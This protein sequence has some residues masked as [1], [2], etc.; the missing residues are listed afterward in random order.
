MKKEVALFFFAGSKGIGLTSHFADISVDLYRKGQQEGCDVYIVSNGKEQN[1]GLWEKVD[2]LIPTDCI[3]KYDETRVG[4]LLCRLEEITAKYPKCIFHLQG[5]SHIRLTKELLKRGNIKGVVTVHS[6]C[7]GNWK[8]PIISFIYSRYISRYISKVIFLSPFACNQFSGSKSL[9]RQGKVV[10]IPFNLPP[11]TAQYEKS[12]DDLVDP[13]NYNIV[14]LANFFKNKGHEKY[15]PAILRFVRE[16]PDARVYFF[17]EGVRR[18]AVMDKIKRAGA[19]QQVFCP[20]RV[21][22]CMVPSILSKSRATLLLSRSENAN[23]A[24]IESL[25]MGIPHIS[26]RVGASEY[27]IQDYVNGI[28]IDDVDG[29]YKALVFLKNSPEQS[30]KMAAVGKEMV[31]AFY[32]YENMLNAYFQLYKSIL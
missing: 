24:A 29:L 11:L 18:Q 25:M 1:P 26:T 10:Y 22:R 15:L 6:F 12:E 7:N 17:G 23:H 30:R 4:Q 14:Y 32:A 9:K 27:F 31:K 28:G 21:P 5:V 8:R 3:I 20:G 16:N 13:S 2:R 19:D